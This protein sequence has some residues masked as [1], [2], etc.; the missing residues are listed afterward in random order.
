MKSTKEMIAVMQ[1][2]EEGNKIEAIQVNGYN[3][4]ILDIPLWDWVHWDY[5]VK[6]E[7]K[8]PTREEITAKWVKDNDVKVGDKVKLGSRGVFHIYEIFGNKILIDLGGYKDFFNI[9]ELKKVT[10]KIIPFTFEDRE[11]FRDKWVINNGYKSEFKIITIGV[12]AVTLAYYNKTSNKT[13]E[14]MLKYFEFIDGTP[15]GKEVWE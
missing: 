11:M 13:Y 9:E 10:K 3:W 2:Y 12:H 14:E 8:E 6:E 5:R 4:E 1:A 7:L 15:F